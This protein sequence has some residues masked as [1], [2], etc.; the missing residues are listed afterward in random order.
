MVNIADLIWILIGGIIVTV[1]LG[2]IAGFSPTL[3]LTQIGI[4]T[5]T[6]KSVS[7]G[8]S[9]MAGVVA[10]LIVL[11]ILFQFFHLTTLIAFIDTTL[12]ALLVSVVF[13]VLVGTTLIIGGI[14]YLRVRKPELKP[15]KSF[16]KS[17]YAA[18]ISFGFFRTFVSITGVTATFIS[19][20]IISEIGPGIVLRL[21]LTLFFL[22]G[23]ILPFV[24]ILFLLKSNPERLARGVSY[25]KEMA[26]KLNYRPVLG[27]GS[28]LFGSSLIIFNVLIAIFY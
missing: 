10:A 7:Y 15:P 1:I 26:H 19:S 27:V 28:I 11:T 18:V 17:G 5:H 16:K 21:F 14:H 23:A 6:K 3:Y 24:G 20:N 2:L 22:A 12:K 8:I 4:G 13:N 25:L 9:I